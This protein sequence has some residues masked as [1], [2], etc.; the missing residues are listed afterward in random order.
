MDTRA[1]L[2]EGI[3]REL[4]SDKRYWQL[5]DE[6]SPDEALDLGR[7]AARAAI[8]PLLLRKMLGDDRFDTTDAALML[9][10]TRQ[11]LHKRAKAG[12]LLGL[13]GRGTTWYPAWQFDVDHRVVRPSAQAVFAAWVDVLGTDFDRS[14]LLAW[15]NSPQPELYDNRPAS[16]ILENADSS[17]LVD[18]ARRAARSL[19]T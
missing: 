5:I 15:A 19:A 4:H 17:A 1:A 11:S 12:R 6:L 2:D 3:Q 9:Q 10:V 8:A 16:W 18:S 14:T 13:P 7:E